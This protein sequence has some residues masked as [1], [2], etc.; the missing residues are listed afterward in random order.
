MK[1]ALALVTLLLSASLTGGQDKMADQLRKG[2]VEEEVNQDL[3]KAI[4]AYQSIL[5][6]YDQGR[7]TAASALFRLAECYRKQG[8]KDEAIAAYKRVV[9]EF[10]DQ[11][12]LTAASRSHL[13]KTYGLSQNELSSLS[14]T[15]IESESL[16]ARRRY[17]ALLEEEIRLME[18][19][20][21]QYQKRIDA[22]T[23][24][25]AG[26]EITKLKKEILELKRTL[27]AFDAGAMPIPPASTRR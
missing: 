26:P 11:N 27:A 21:A 19:Q 9:Q 22:R 14:A 10:P 4:Q 15:G 17:R 24:S 7:P 16:A 23:I 2:I 8:K 20:M 12:K 1:T 6:Q 3:D 18:N 13:S 5:T 25:A